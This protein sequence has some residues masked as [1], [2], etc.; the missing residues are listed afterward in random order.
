MTAPSLTQGEAADRAA[1]IDVRAYDIEV[2]FTGL[3]SGPEVRCTSTIRFGFRGNGTS[4]FVDCAAQVV[5]ASLN[6][7]PILPAAISPRR[8]A[9]G[10]LAAENVLVVSTVQ[11]HT[12]TGLG[13]HKAVDPADGEVYVWTT[14]EPDECHHVWACFDQPDLK[15]PH[16]FTVRA[17]TAW[18]VLSNC[19]PAH[20]EATGPTA[21]STFPATPPL[22][23]YNVVVLGGPFV[24]MRAERDGYDLGLYARASLRSVLER[25]AQELFGLTAQGLAFFGERFDMPFPERRYDQAF[26]PEFGGAMEN[27]GCV[28]WDDDVLYRND[29]TEFERQERALILLH[30][31]AHMWFG[32]IVTMHWW[33]DL[34][35][36]EAFAEFAA[37][38][39]AEAATEFTDM[40]AAHLARG[41]LQAYIADQGPMSHPIRQ[42]VPD[43][44]AAAGT[45]DRI[46]YPKG[47]SVLYQL[48][49][50][51]GE[52]TFI[53]GLRS[54]FARYAWQ[55][56]TLDDLTD[57]LATASGKNVAAWADGWLATA[58][59]D[60]LRFERIADTNLL[61]AEGPPGSAPRPHAMAVGIYRP[62]DGRLQRI[63]LMR[64][65]LD[66]PQLVLPPIDASDLVLVN[67]DNLTFATVLPG[68]AST[69]QLLAAASLLPTPLS[70]AVAVATIWNLVA[71]GRIATSDA[72]TSLAGVIRAE[73]TQS[74]LEPFVDLAITAAE[75]WAPDAARELLL[76]ELADVCLEL[77]ARSGDRAVALRGLARTAVTSTQLEALEAAADTA[78]L[79]WRTLI[80]LAQHDAAPEAAIIDTE[81]AD[82]DPD[83]WVRALAVRAAR[84]SAAD[85]DRT[86]QA[87]VVDKVVPV[88][89]FSAVAQAF[90]RPDQADL[91]APYAHRYLDLLPDMGRHGMVFGGVAAGNMFPSIGIGDEFL[92]E[93]DARVGDASLAPV[94]ANRAV[95][96]ADE[97]RRMLAA[98][99][100]DS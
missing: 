38:W 13:V 96:R 47:A 62:A 31:Q 29:P 34:W 27:Y 64:V 17:P 82:P 3:V 18:T 78:D 90:W 41:Q 1:L 69:V 32:N 79:R 57:E 12:A 60:R 97:V 73:T 59:V 35:L 100:R 67:D 28:T 5:S 72:V 50:Y 52:D 39:A 85:K 6:G 94:V 10:G 49:T 53:D 56:T 22:S 88:A 87:L 8:V 55:N 42:R 37:H 84:P 99:R 48:M 83:A 46:T 92:A 95:E 14:F 21:T 2:D 76:R 40:W 36:N 80:R 4:T 58:G 45:F 68:D 25:D 74:L 23:A 65:V 19:G 75:W 93:F 51:L 24:E 77:G 81:A 26:V 66:H 70:R 71:T 91:L 89:A 86:W 54:Y 7:S 16:T 43:V 15:A 33:D 11:A 30:E 63:E 44:A 98:R 20:V 9:L 61:V